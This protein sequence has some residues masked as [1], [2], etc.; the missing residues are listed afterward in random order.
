MY[1]DNECVDFTC[2]NG[3]WRRQGEQDACVL[4]SCTQVGLN[5]V[6]TNLPKKDPM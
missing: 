2:D 5:I 1:N 4:D 6:L 3:K